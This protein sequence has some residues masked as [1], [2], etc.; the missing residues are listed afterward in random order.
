MYEAYVTRLLLT[1]RRLN[2]QPLGALR[3]PEGAVRLTIASAVLD[4]CIPAAGD[5]STYLFNRAIRGR[6][7]RNC[8]AVCREIPLH[9]RSRRDPAGSVL[10]FV[11]RNRD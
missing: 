9:L 6:L 8:V 10:D 7:H 5:E 2:L 11:T 3:I 4:D 1:R